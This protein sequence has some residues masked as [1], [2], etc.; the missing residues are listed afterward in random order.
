MLIHDGGGN[1][2]ELL[3]VQEDI[4]RQVEDMFGIVLEREP[5]LVV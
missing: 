1:T 4:V 3:S 2:S 5:N